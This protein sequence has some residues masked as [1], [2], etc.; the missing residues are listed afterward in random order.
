VGSVISS[1]VRR[2]TD[3]SIIAGGT[4]NFGNITAS[5]VTANLTGSATQ[6]GGVPALQATG[7]NAGA[8]NQDPNTSL[9][10]YI[11]TNHIN[12]PSGAYHWH[13]RTQFYG[14]KLDT[15]NRAQIAI[16][17]NS[18]GSNSV[19]TR[20]KYGGIWSQWEKSITESEVSINSAYNSV[21][22]RDS[23]GDINARLFRSDYD[24]TNPTCN[25]FMTQVDTVDNNYIRPSTSAQVSAALQI[26]KTNSAQAL[27]AT[28]A[29]R[30]VGDRVYLYKGNGTYEYIDIPAS[31]IGEGQTIAYYT[32]SIGTTYTNVTG[33][34]IYIA[35]TAY[36]YGEAILYVD[37]KI[38]GRAYSVDN[39]RPVRSVMSYP[40][41]NGKSYYVTVNAS[42]MSIVNWVEMR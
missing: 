22:R 12:T 9:D 24:T 19:Y 10:E 42:T 39:N 28:D 13:I 5:T 32:R 30:I 34:T 26:T 38:V 23:S 8:T 7:V 21:V 27:H 25:Y 2:G 11:M 36:G 31:G 33:R 37:G 40:V 6:I 17:Y 16:K 1:V 29:L 18:G 14:N 41:P 3:G 20:S 35:M 4:S 15:S